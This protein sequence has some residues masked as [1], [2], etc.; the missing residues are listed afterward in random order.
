M[1]KDLSDTPSRHSDFVI[2]HSF[3]HVAPT[4]LE[5][6]V[7][8]EAINICAPNGA[9]IDGKIGTLWRMSQMKP[10]MLTRE[11][12]A[13]HDDLRCSHQRHDNCQDEE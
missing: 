10:I 2:R 11:C 4:E 8:D 9:S 12:D 13:V 5:F 3:K 1:K 7:D 6:L